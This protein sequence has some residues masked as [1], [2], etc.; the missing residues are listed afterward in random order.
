MRTP[1]GLMIFWRWM[2]G[3]W[4][5]LSKCPCAA[6]LDLSV[7]LL[8]SGGMVRM[9]D[10]EWGQMSVW[11]KSFGKQEKLEIVPM[12]D[13]MKWRM[14]PKSHTVQIIYK[15][16]STLGTGS[17]ELR[18]LLAALSHFLSV[19]T[20]LSFLRNYLWFYHCP[21]I[22][23]PFLPLGSK[24]LEIAIGFCWTLR[25]TCNDETWKR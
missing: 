7:M 15:G 8:K 12:K 10:G 13:I 21:S 22:P 1:C 11:R 24:N 6:N 2:L 17:T 25:Y 20:F 19:K 3:F 18:T 4:C 5:Y 23:G 9:Q 16:L 14:Y